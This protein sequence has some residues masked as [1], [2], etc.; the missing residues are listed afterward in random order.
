MLNA[1]MV[2]MIQCLNYSLRSDISYQRIWCDMKWLEYEITG[3]DLI[4]YLIGMWY[5]VCDIKY[6]MMLM[7]RWYVMR[8]D[9]MIWYDTIQ[10]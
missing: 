2:K 1:V 10:K 3:Y 8:W 7:D 4:L 9:D 5:M 6:A